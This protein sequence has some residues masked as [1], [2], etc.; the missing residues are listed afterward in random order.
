MS[1][2]PRFHPRRFRPRADVPRLIAHRG[3]SAEAPENTLPAFE[4]AA[5]AGFTWVEFDVMLS[6]D[7]VAMV[8]HD[9]SLKRT[10][11]AKGR[12][13]ETAAADLQRLDAGSWF[14]SQFV[15]ARIPTLAETLAALTR[16]GLGANVEIKPAKGHEEET[17]ETVA[18]QLA[19]DWPKSLPPPVV[20][21]FSEAA[22][23]AAHSTHPAH[24]Y[25]PLFERIPDDWAARMQAV[26]ATALHCNAKRLTKRRAEEVTQ[27]GA[28]VRCYTVNEAAQS[29]TLYSQGVSTLFCDRRPD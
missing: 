18:A 28:A 3:L 20:S 29:A 5:A 4:A 15:G 16:L 11:G 25:A 23:R 12:V 1:G 6:A 9:E 10:T 21:S 27:S 19:A 14:G 8:I 17:G 13:S 7:G 24:D 26:G 22:L 2:P